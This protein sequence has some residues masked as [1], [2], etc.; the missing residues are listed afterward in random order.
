M[1]V[2]A[3][4]TSFFDLLES[5]QPSPTTFAWFTLTSS[6]SIHEDDYICTGELITLGESHTQLDKKTYV[7]TVDRLIRCDC[8]FHSDYKQNLTSAVSMLPLRN[9]RLRKI[10]ER[11]LC[12]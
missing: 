9:P 8:T 4:E 5:K 11:D 12:L 7:L 10:E 6:P 2:L 3:P 1:S